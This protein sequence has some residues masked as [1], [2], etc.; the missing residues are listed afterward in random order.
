LLLSSKNY[1]A[2]AKSNVLFRVAKNHTKSM[3]KK[4]GGKTAGEVL[5]VGL[6]DCSTEQAVPVRWMGG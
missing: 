3:T 6:C 1:Y 5:C 2:K 4:I